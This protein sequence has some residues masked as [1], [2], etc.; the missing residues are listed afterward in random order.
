M[1]LPNGSQQN[2]VP[3]FLFFL[4]RGAAGKIDLEL[5]IGPVVWGSE[6]YS[7]RYLKL[8]AMS[9]VAVAASNSA[10]LVLLKTLLAIFGVHPIAWG[11][12]PLLLN[13]F[14]PSRTLDL[15]SASFIEA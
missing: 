5:V 9:N 8:V 1:L 3:S 11:E 13:T 15:F 14:I 10:V 2:F 6:I 7:V 12:L 4:D